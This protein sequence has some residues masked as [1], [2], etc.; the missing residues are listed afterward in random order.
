MLIKRFYLL[1]KKERGGRKVRKEGEVEER[2]L[3]RKGRGERGGREGKG[4]E[5]EGNRRE[6]DGK[7]EE[8]GKEERKVNYRLFVFVFFL[9]L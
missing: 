8:K 3:R 2:E 5:G 7:G 9:V 4:G 1:R 6:I